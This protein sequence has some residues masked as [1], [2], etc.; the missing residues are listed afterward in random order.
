MVPA[1]AA[2]IV[3]GARDGSTGRLAYFQRGGQV[4]DGSGGPRQ[5]R[6]CLRTP[7][8]RVQ[9]FPLRGADILSAAAYVRSADV[10]QE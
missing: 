1:Q 3:G 6:M 2:I 9:T 4:L 5:Q 7:L 10:D 8:Y